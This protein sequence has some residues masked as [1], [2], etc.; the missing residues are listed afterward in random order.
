MF[1]WHGG[2]RIEAEIDTPPVKNAVE[3]LRRD[4]EKT[5]GKS[6]EE[7]G[8]IRL[9]AEKESRSPTKKSESMPGRIWGSSTASSI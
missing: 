6:G 3:A 8:A 5:L 1:I 4:M 9:I 7:T 2:T